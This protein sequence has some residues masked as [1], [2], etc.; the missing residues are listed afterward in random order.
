MC[1]LGTNETD[2]LAMGLMPASAGGGGSNLWSARYVFKQSYKVTNRSGQTLTSVRFYQ[3]I[4]ALQSTAAV[5]DDRQYGGQMSGY[6]YTLTQWGDTHALHSRRG[7][8]YNM[9]DYLSVSANWMP[10]G[11]EVGLFASTNH[12]YDFPDT[13]TVAA[14]E[15]NSPLNGN[16]QIYTNRSAFVCGVMC[17]EFGS[18][19]PNAMT[20]IDFILSVHTIRTLMTNIPPV[21]VV[22]D[23]VYLENGALNAVVQETTG[24]PYANYAMQKTTDL[25]IRKRDWESI[26]ISVRKN[27]PQMGWDTIT[28]PPGVGVDQCYIGVGATINETPIIPTISF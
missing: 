10:N 18:L 23:R 19:P 14:I 3:F 15:N 9:R 7:T 28:A 24:N 8:T 1:D 26:P 13:G 17:F 27:Y 22:V 21:N 11:L 4:H 25:N 12:Q 20:N 5:Y 6:R 2:R 16:D